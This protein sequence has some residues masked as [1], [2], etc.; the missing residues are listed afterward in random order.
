MVWGG[1][2]CFTRFASS[3]TN[4]KLVLIKSN[5]LL[6]HLKSY[7]KPSQSVTRK[8]DDDLPRTMMCREDRKEQG[9][10]NNWLF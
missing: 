9:V 2:E 8:G 1:K 10:P 3:V 7:V 4:E 5:E 6:A